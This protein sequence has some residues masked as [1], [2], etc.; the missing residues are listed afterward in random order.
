MLIDDFNHT[1]DTWI[2]ELEGYTFDQLSLKPSPTSWSLGQV[3]MHLAENT[4]YYID[5]IKICITNNEN[6]SGESSSAAKTMFKNNEFPDEQLEGPPDNLATPQPDS[7]EQLLSSL[8]SLK[9]E[10]NAVA[11]LMIG[12]P[13]KGKTKHPGLDY[14]SAQE[15]LQFSDMHLRHH[16]RQK[17]RIDQFLKLQVT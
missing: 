3:Y 10:M 11:R 15:W 2:N 8:V 6:I 4:E 5:Q 9:D 14:F 17:A 1:I 16:F 7:R 12:S 13:F